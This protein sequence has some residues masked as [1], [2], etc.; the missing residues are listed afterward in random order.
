RKGPGMMWEAAA[1]KVRERGGV[2]EMGRK[3]VGCEWNPVT[4]T[5]TVTHKAGDGS[6]SETHARHV[7]SSAPM[8]Q[9]VHGIT[10][11]VSAQAR[12]AASSLKYR[13]FMTVMVILKD[14]DVFTDN[15]IY[16]HDSSVKVARVQN[17]KSWSPEMVPDPSMACYGLEY[18]CFE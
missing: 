10:P 1:K 3:V 5:W 12:H 17:F 15:W 16:I 8:R 13:D 6:T 14:R 18:F 7:I 2:I 4:E 9:L 11:A